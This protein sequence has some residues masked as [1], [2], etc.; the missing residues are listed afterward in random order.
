MQRFEGISFRVANSAMADF[1]NDALQTNVFS[2]Y[3]TLGTGT[4]TVTTAR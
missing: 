4:L 3:V 1:L 2:P